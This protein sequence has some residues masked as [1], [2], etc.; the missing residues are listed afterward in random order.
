MV[1]KMTVKNQIT[2]PK[3]ILEAVGLANLKK[4]EMY[5]D[6]EAKNHGIF[7]KPMTVTVEERIPQEQWQKFETRAAKID[8]GDEVFDS[9]EKAAEFLKKRVKK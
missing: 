5:F 3:R 1:T 8:K 6:I 7:L 9:P 2:I 4:D